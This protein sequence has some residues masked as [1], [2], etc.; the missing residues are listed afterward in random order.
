MPY[1]MLRHNTLNGYAD[2]VREA[3]LL[4]KAWGMSK[5]WV[6]DAVW[7]TAYYFTGMEVLSG[8]S[9]LAAVLA[10]WDAPSPLLSNA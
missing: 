5:E 8:L 7:W 6:V 3:A 4:G 10:A 9:G 2:G 1:L